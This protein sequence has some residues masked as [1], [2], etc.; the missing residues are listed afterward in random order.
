MAQLLFIKQHQ[1]TV[2]QI[3][4]GFFLAAAILG[5]LMRFMFILEVPFL[6]Y[7]Y[8]LH[9]HSHTAMLGWGFI[10]LGAAIVFKF[11]PNL[12]EQSHYRYIFLLS[13]VAGIGMLLSFLYQG[14]GAIS[15]AFST[16]HV[17]VAYYFAW[18]VRK[19]LKR[20]GSSEATKFA[21]WAIYLMVLSTVGLWAIA[22]V[23][24]LL[25]K[26]HPLYF[27]SIQFFL[28][29]QFNGWFTYGILALIFKHSE[30]NGYPVK[31]PRG[32]FAILQ[33]SLLLT[34]ALSITWSTP[35]SY[36]FYLNSAGVLLQ[37]VAFVLLGIGFTRSAMLK[38][39]QNVLAGWL[40]RLGI[41][42][43]GFKVL[44]QGAVA[45]PFIAQVS[46]TIRNFAIGFIH[47]TMLGAFSLTLMAMLLKDK[48]IPE[49]RLAKSGYLLLIAG[50][51]LSE[52]LLFV[53]GL[54]LWAG[55]GFIPAYYESIFGVS[56]F[57]PIALSLIILAMMK[58]NQYEF[59]TIKVI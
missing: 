16:L 11:L 27:S 47:L 57:L 58:N 8:V 7:K 29:F 52:L 34:Y 24:I 26:L 35:E 43:L 44:I 48:L 37:V 2:I 22:P 20:M 6:E 28:H 38:F 51:T 31:L 32:T 1:R 36:L 15:I 55:K 5:A 21:K 14:Y 19:D 56:A 53:Q 23:S 9:A 18:T 40:F 4:I 59:S 49:N 39:G 42:S 25:G 3:A 13:T 33:V 45:I 12:L 30:D 54:L 50:F 41:L 17:L 10:A 46:Y